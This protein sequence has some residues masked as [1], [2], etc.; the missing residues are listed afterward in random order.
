[1][2]WMPLTRARDNYT[3]SVDGIRFLMQDGPVAVICQIG[4]ETLSRF[5]STVGLTQLTEI[6]DHGRATI[7]R[8]ASDKYD[9]TS[10]R[11]YEV[12]IVTTADMGLERELKTG[13]PTSAGGI[14]D[15]E[16]R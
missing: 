1:M 7:E 8:A 15:A 13:L 10:R 12:L 6:F 2:S 16:T 3:L 9:R 5:G 14:G 4:L 11:A